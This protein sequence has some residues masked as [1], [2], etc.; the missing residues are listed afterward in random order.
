MIDLSQALQCVDCE[1][2]LRMTRKGDE[3]VISCSKYLKGKP[4][5]NYHKQRGTL[6][7]WIS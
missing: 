4:C 2:L 7:R 6:G 5:E 1:H 3:M